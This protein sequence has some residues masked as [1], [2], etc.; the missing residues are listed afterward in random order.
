MSMKSIQGRKILLSLLEFI[1]G[2]SVRNNDKWIRYPISLPGGELRGNVRLAT[3]REEWD[4]L[5]EGKYRFG[6]NELFVFRAL[7]EVLENLEKQLP[8]GAIDELC[9]RIFEEDVQSRKNSG[10]QWGS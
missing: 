1:V 5:M 8:P 9:E 4:D 6:A 7:D 3:L 10:N 2:K